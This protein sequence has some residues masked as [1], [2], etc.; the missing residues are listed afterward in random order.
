MEQFARTC[1]VE[2]SG[3][4]DVTGST[5]LIDFALTLANNPNFRVNEGGILHW[6]QRNTSTMDNV[7]QTFGDTLSQ[8]SGNLHIWRGVLS[9]LTDN[10]RLDGFS[11]QF[12]R[13]VGLEIVSPLIHSFAL[14]QPVTALEPIVLNWDCSHNPPATTA[15]ISWSAPNRTP[16]SQVVG[17]SGTQPIVTA[18]QKG[19]YEFLLT[20]TIT[21]DGEA[22]QATR[23]LTV[24]VS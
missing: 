11:S 16:G 5:A 20:A 18:A 4:K 3:L 13:Q 23:T 10:G 7:Q 6:G 14:Q 9:N 22:R 1:A 12:T 24:T 21:L 17:L 15:Q 8:P 19:T 2:I